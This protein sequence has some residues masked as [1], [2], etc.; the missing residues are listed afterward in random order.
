MYSN[1]KTTADELCEL[2]F[3]RY[4]VNLALEMTNQNKASAIEWL[5]SDE[6]KVA[7]KQHPNSNSLDNKKTAS[8][9]VSPFSDMFDKIRS[10]SDQVPNRAQLSCVTT[11]REHTEYMNMSKGDAISDFQI[12]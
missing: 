11:N 6:F 2:G 10:Q 3:E 8:S 9:S 4:W 12:L 1:S 5:L 7:Q